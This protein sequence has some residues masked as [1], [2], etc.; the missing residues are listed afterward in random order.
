M[1]IT[2][3][4]LKPAL[5]F[6]ADNCYF[7]V[8]LGEY[9]QMI[10]VTIKLSLK[11]LPPF[12][13]IMEQLYQIGVASLP[14][15]A[16]TGFSTGLVLAAQS[17]YQLADKGLASVTGLMVAKAMMTE[18]GPV[19]T[20]FMITGRVGASMCAELG[21]MQ[22][23]EQIDALRTMAVHP[24]RYLIAPRLISGVVMMPMLTIFS[25]IMGIFGGYL[26]SVYFFHMAHSTYFDPMQT[27]IDIFDLC[28]GIVKSFVFGFIILTVACYKG[29]S[30][31]GGA[32]GVGRYTTNSVVITYCCILLVNFFLTMT[33]NILRGEI[34]KVL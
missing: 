25:I 3:K 13:L 2:E 29:I 34:D 7:L 33:M 28:T 19:M 18:L 31:T 11:K 21:T 15:V 9:L 1:R 5:N 16:I 10:L 24:Y 26:I 12:P 8:Q 4:S 30:T 14:V 32:A 27:N 6:L 23:T 22:V 17:F 20:A